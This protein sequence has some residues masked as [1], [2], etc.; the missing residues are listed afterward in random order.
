ILGFNA[1]Q[2][3]REGFSWDVP[4]DSDDSETSPYIGFTWTLT[5][6]L[7][8]YASYSDI[9]Q[10]QYELNDNQQ[11]LGPAQGKS[12]EAGIKKKW[13]DD[14]LLTSFALFQVEQTNLAEFAQYSDCDD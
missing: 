10:P 3:E 13:L 5:Q 9:Y 2:Y 6:D 4:T 11:P 12:Y 8:A 7:N 14:A 1:V